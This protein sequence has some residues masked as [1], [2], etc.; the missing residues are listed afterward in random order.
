MKRTVAM[1][2]GLILMVGLVF[3]NGQ[4]EKN[5]TTTEKMVDFPKKEITVVVPWNPGPTT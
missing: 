5:G 2:S 3:A 4:T 1:F